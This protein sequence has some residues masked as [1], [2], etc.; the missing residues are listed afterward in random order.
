LIISL[1][2]RPS[3][4]IGQEKNLGNYHLEK[5]NGAAS[6]QKRVFPKTVRKGSKVEVRRQGGGKARLED[7]KRWGTSSRGVPSLSEKSERGS[8]DEKRCGRVGALVGGG[9][10]GRERA[11][12]GYLKKV[13][14]AWSQSR[15]STGSGNRGFGRGK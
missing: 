9:E 2:I 10:G 8:V 5:R 6:L 11:F 13:K 4:L 1:G 3:P 15:S 7:N 14:R 12:L